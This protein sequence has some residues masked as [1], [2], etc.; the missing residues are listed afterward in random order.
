MQNADVTSPRYLVDAS[1]DRGCTP[2]SV[3]LDILY[4]EDDWTK[5]RGRACRGQ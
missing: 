5:M 1:N 3:Q 2:R 4:R